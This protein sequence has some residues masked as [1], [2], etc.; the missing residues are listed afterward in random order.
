[1]TTESHF[2]TPVLLLA[3]NR[4]ETTA[5]VFDAIRQA[6]PAKLYVAADGPRTSRAGEAERCAEVRRLVTAVDWPC[7]VQTLFREENLGCKRG[8]GTAIDW[9]FSR[10]ERGIVLE[11]DCLP[12]QSF[13]RFCEVLLERLRDDPRVF[14]IQGNFFGSGKTPGSSYVYSKMF[15]MWGWAGWADR[16]RSVRVG[17]VDATAVRRALQVEDWLGAGFW[18]RE[19]WLAVLERQAAGLIDSWGYPVQFHCFAHGLFNATPT[20][21]LVLNIGQ[22]PSAT[23]TVDLAPG[24]FNRSAR[25]IEFPLVDGTKYE[26]HSSMFRFE[27]RWRSQLTPWIVFRQVMHRR[28]PR[29]YAALRAALHGPGA[30]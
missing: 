24:P 26:G 14:A 8:V 3:F 10:E 12:S 2:S 29:L 19:Y 28:F 21:N 18:I 22:G 9:F 16:W 15:Y 7:R 6:R 4:P 17:D 27:R 30:S 1:M 23:R 5:R 20:K 13:F 25:E 11:D